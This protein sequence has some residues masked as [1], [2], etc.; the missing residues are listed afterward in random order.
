MEVIENVTSKNMWPTTTYTFTVN[1]IDNEQIKNKCLEREKQGLGFRFDPIQ[2]GGWQS[3]KDLLDFEF[4]DL[5]SL[6]FYQ[7]HYLLK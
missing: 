6:E 4:L 2:G 1:N 7:S 3:N 5:N